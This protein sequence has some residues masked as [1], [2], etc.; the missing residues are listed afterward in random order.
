[1]HV[2][3]WYLH[4]VFSPFFNKLSSQAAL[5][6]NINTLAVGDKAL[7]WEEADIQRVS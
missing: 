7:L 1:V 4:T 6:T 2:E 5:F 3:S